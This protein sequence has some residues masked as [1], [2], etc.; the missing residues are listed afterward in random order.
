MLIAWPDDRFTLER[1]PRGAATGERYAIDVQQ[2]DRLIRKH[3]LRGGENRVELRR[4]LREAFRSAAD[5]L[6]S[7][8]DAERQI[9]EAMR[10]R[11]DE[12]D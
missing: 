9:A 11:R 6:A 3:G 2:A 12:N 5:G 8:A 10:R 7:L 1:R 4:K